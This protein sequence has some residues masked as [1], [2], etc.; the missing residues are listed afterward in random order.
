VLS[1]LSTVAAVA[2]VVFA[3]TASYNLQVEI[4]LHSPGENMVRFQDCW[5]KKL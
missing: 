2:L 5:T 4:I 3:A 1:V